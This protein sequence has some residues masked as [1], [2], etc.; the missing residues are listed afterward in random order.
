MTQVL[1]ITNWVKKQIYYL[2]DHK[3]A[4]I[5][6]HIYGLL[7]VFAFFFIVYLDIRKINRDYVEADYVEDDYIP[8]WP[9]EG[10]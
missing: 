7:F 9:G 5:M 8:E 1:M 6:S 2:S 4:Y 10:F 3:K